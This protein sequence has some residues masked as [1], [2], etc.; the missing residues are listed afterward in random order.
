MGLREQP[1]QITQGYFED[2]EDLKDF[3]DYLFDVEKIGVYEELYNK[4]QKY[5]ENE[6][7][8]KN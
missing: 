2:A 1:I 3:V 5:Q 4:F 7:N 8:N 6:D